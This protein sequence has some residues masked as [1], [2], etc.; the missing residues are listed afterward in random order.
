MPTNFIHLRLKS[1]YSLLESA[2]KIDTIIYAAKK[3]NM[4]AV[5]MTDHN[6]LFGM[7]EFAMSASKAKIQAIHGAVI[8]MRH[9]SEVAEILVIAKDHAGY[10][11]LLK[12]V[13]HIYTQENRAPNP[14][15][16][17]DDLFTESSTEGGPSCD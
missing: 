4:H 5:A 6:N 12:L 1:A 16:T 10:K 3:H 17:F 7:L 13:S 15:I 2:M 8:N 9:H 14:E 11:N